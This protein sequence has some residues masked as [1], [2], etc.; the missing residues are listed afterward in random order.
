MGANAPEE[1]GDYYA[2]GDIE[3]VINYTENNSKTYNKKGVPGNIS[4]N[5]RYDAAHAKWGGSWR[6][7]TKDEFEE[8]LKYCTWTWI[9]RNGVNGYEIKSNKNGNSIFLP[10]AGW[11]RGLSLSDDG[12]YGSYWS[13][14]SGG[15]ESEGAYYLGFL[16]DARSSG[17]SNR[18]YGRSVR[19]VSAGI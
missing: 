18:Y 16:N 5:P 17:W 8:L 15:K 3:A 12:T 9:L 19:P 4:G 13:A 11:R 7:P 10:A 14:M 6:I 2:W 1:N